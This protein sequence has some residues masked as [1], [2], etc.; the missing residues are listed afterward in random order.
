MTEQRDRYLLPPPGQRRLIDTT[1]RLRAVLPDLESADALGVDTETEVPARERHPRLALIQIA[2]DHLAV[3]IDPLRLAAEDLALLQVVM[4][5]ENI[6]KVFVGAAQDCAMLLSVGLTLR[7]VCDISDASRS[8]FGKGTAGL[9]AMAERAFGVV[10]D[11]SLQRSPWLR[12]PLTPPLL[13]YAYRDAE[14]TLA[15]YRWFLAGYRDIV[16]MHIRPEAQVTLPSTLPAWL[17][18]VLQGRR[19]EN[20]RDRLDVWAILELHSLSAEQ[21]AA[22]LIAACRQALALITDPHI[23]ARLITTVAT[24]DLYEMLDDLAPA[25]HSLSALERGAAARAFGQLGTADDVER[26]Q[27]LAAADSVTEVQT[28]AARSIRQ[29]LTPPGTDEEP[30]DTEDTAP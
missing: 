26:L 9:Q 10:I 14:V 27:A 7:G 11:K 25:L 5:N 20:S 15:V 28:A 4:G 19:V 2:T 30:P 24:L 29:L 16:A 21:D 18:D 17:L 22:A 3:A 1:E 13:A 8:A 6:I 12:R 23:R